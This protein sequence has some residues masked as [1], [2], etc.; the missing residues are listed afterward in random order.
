[1]HTF[2]QGAWGGIEK[3]L[4][5]LPPSE[6]PKLSLFQIERSSFR[7]QN[8]QLLL[9]QCAILCVCITFPLLRF[10]L[11]NS[12]NCCRAFPEPSSLSS[13]AVE[14]VPLVSDQAQR[15]HCAG[16]CH[17]AARLVIGGN[18]SFRRQIT[19]RSPKQSRVCALSLTTGTSPQLWVR[20]YCLI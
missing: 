5:S 1:M 7:W 19:A 15:L 4:L 18:G 9:S 20:S 3:S 13:S 12:S 16:L 8:K 2:L 14:S 11:V 6:A 10:P 17:W